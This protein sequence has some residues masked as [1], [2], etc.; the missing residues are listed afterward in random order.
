LT[1]PVQGPEFPTGL[2]RYAD[3]PEVTAC[4]GILSSVLQGPLES[5]LSGHARSIEV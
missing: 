1:S 5:R 3:I 4:S 2:L